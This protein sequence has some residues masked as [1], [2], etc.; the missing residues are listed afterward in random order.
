MTTIPK[1]NGRSARSARCRLVKRILL[2]LV[3]FAILY[4][5][6]PIDS[7]ALSSGRLAMLS[8]LLYLALTGRPIY[9]AHDWK[10]LLIFLP[11]PYVILQY[12]LV[13]DPG[14]L[15]RFAHLALYSLVG[16]SIVARLA[17][18]LEDLLKIILTAI[19]IQAVIILYS[20]GSLEYRAWFESS[21]LSGTN[22]QASD[23]YR[24][25]GLTS[26]G[27]SALSVIQS[28]GVMVGGTL[29]FL[30]QPARSPVP[31]IL[32]MLLCAL[33]C[34]VVGR[35]GLL[36]SS[37]FLVMFCVGAGYAWGL[38]AVGGSLVVALFVSL[39]H[40][41]ELMPSGFSTDNFLNWALGFFLSG[42]DESVVD[43]ASMPVHALAP[44]DA[45]V[46]TGLISPI[47]GGNPSGHD[48]GFVQ[49]YFSMGLLMSTAFYALYA[50]VLLHLLRWLPI[51]L[52]WTL[53][54]MF[55]AIEIKEPFVFK[56]GTM[57]VLVA[58]YSSI[59]RSGS[60][61]ALRDRTRASEVPPPE[62]RLSSASGSFR[63]HG[64]Y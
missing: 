13:Y 63:S 6:S 27:G 40:F 17:G 53:A 45:M 29:L 18:S 15:S 52:K 8:L 48:S 37:V 20:F 56:Y 62:H 60:V 61:R 7:D 24:A 46:G 35:T 41:A 36:L 58:I 51:T 49:A 57:F 33:S 22:F 50:L 59:L 34:V 28:L 12:A 32:L 42:T 43:L 19:T 44:L 10:P 64:R 9:R 55:F 2:T 31:I 21:V 3:T 26:T 30:R 5:I 38:L 25:P 47:A 16:A 39:P 54:A 1:S 23:L 11:L 4:N 14:Q